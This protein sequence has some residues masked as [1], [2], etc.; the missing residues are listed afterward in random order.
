MHNFLDKCMLPLMQSI[1]RPE[2]W[3]YSPTGSANNGMGHD[4]F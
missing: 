3:N 4:R 1:K 2:G